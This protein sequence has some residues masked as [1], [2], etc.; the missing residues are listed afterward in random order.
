MIT[1][2]VYGCVLFGEITEVHNA[3]SHTATSTGESV[4]GRTKIDASKT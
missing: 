3:P 4:D 2:E 1:M